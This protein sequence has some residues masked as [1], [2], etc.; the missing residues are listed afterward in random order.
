MNRWLLFK[1]FV[2]IGINGYSQTSKEVD[3]WYA[4]PVLWIGSSAFLIILLIYILYKMLANNSRHKK[5]IL[6]NRDESQARPV[7]PNDI[8]FEEIERQRKFN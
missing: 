7:N 2:I 8:S 6:E 3:Q 5:T 1:I 4:D